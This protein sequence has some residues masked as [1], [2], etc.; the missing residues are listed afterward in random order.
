MLRDIDEQDLLKAGERFSPEV[1]QIETYRLKI[2]RT[3]AQENFDITANESFK[4]RSRKNIERTLLPSN[5]DFNF[6]KSGQVIPFFTCP[7]LL[8][9]HPEAA[10]TNLPGST[11]RPGHDREEPP[12]VLLHS[13]TCTQGS[14]SD[15]LPFFI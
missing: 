9:L 10:S 11:S 14:F 3:Q 4:I 5:V 1:Y 13:S 7:Q 6:K 8:F 12:R 2:I 15:A